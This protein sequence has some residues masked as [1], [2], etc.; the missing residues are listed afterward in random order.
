M[1][2][3]SEH[4]WPQRKA[5]LKMKTLRLSL[6]IALLAG[7]SSWAQ[8]ASPPEDLFLSLQLEGPSTVREVRNAQLAAGEVSLRVYDASPKILPESVHV[9]ALGALH[10]LR[11]RQQFVHFEIL[12]QRRVLETLVGRDVTLKRHFEYGSETVEGVLLQSPTALTPHGE[13]SVPVFVSSDDGRVRM[14]ED[15]EPILDVVP[16]GDWNRLRLDWRLQVARSDR[17]RFEL[18]YLTAG[19]H[20]TPHYTLRLERGSERG[21]LLGLALVENATG[22]S[23]PGARVQ[24]VTQTGSPR[25]YQATDSGS[26]PS[27]LPIEGV[28]TLPARQKTQVVFYERQD[29]PLRRVATLFPADHPQGKP[30]RDRT[31]GIF[32][33]LEI[34]SSEWSDSAV[35]LPAG[36]ADVYQVED[37]GR[38]TLLARSQ[39]GTTSGADAVYLAGDPIVG[40]VAQRSSSPSGPG[41]QHVIRIFSER[42]DTLFVE[43]MQPL[44]IRQ[45]VRQS[46][47]SPRLIQPSLA[48]FSISVPSGGIAELTYA[49]VH[50]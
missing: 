37:D 28:V 3:K 1:L 16:P 42:T 22:M 29:L 9:R 5:N 20:F 12:D 18:T 2:A 48:V 41:Q 7:A 47:V 23:F 46:S 19:L 43:V 30:G 34:D 8:E 35:V 26:V 31:I 39:I 38:A 32:E 44:G 36:P 6:G 4:H 21:H 49:V 45:V 14:L 13:R 15:A 27:T 33:R 24:L 40:L 25:P 11:F 50:E 10:D 17:Y